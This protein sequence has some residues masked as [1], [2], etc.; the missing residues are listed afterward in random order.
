MRQIV[1]LAL[2]LFLASCSERKSPVSAIDADKFEK[3]Y[4]EL[5]D[6]ALVIQAQ[7]DSLVS[8]VA[9][10]ILERHEVTAEQFR[11]TVREYNNDT[12]VWK[13]FYDNVLLRID[14]R[15]K[16]VPPP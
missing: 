6:S 16:R 8:P 9:E 14:E 11:A 1:T 10:R 13:E 3:I 2:L 7:P 5:V 15:M 12:R 4:L